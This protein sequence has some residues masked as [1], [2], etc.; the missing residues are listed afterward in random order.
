[1][2]YRAIYQAFK[3]LSFFTGPI[4][5]IA[6]ISSMYKLMR[7]CYANETKVTSPGDF[8]TSPQETF[9]QLYPLRTSLFRG[10]PQ[11]SYLS[12]MLCPIRFNFSPVT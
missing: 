9:S 10:G 7:Q 4:D 6:I 8:F 5:S 1:M 3:F 2:N 12:M 11:V